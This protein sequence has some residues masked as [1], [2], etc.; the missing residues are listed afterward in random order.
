MQLSGRKFHLT[1]ISCLHMVLPSDTEICASMAYE[2]GIYIEFYS[3]PGLTWNQFWYAP[4]G[5]KIRTFFAVSV[6][7]GS[8]Q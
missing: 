3:Q 2:Q 6:A 5:E 7:I 8:Q 1:L 4:S